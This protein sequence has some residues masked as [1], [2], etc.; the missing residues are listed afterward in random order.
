[1]VLRTGILLAVLMTLF[2]S[3]PGRGETVM[4]YTYYLLTGDTEKAIVELKK[5]TVE[6]GGYVRFFS[7]TSIVLRAP[8]LSMPLL[9]KTVSG[10]G[11][12]FDEQLYRR[13]ITREVMELNTRLK[14]KDKL[15]DDLYALFTTSKFHQTLDIEKEIGKVIMEIEDIKGKL[16]Y[17]RDRVE[18]SEIT[19]YLNQKSAAKKSGTA[20]AYFEWI[21]SLGVPD[22]LNFWK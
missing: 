3:V 18:L 12:I 2:S 7:E 20:R 17:Y 4:K 19:I 8:E 21:R 5:T 9:R 1:M 15:L 6:T 13:D 22:I 10:L 16:S 14:V 11:Y